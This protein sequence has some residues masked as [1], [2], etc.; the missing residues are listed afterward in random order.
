VGFT[1]SVKLKVISLVILTMFEICTDTMAHTKLGA[2]LSVVV[3]DDNLGNFAHWV[4]ELPNL[5]ESTSKLIITNY[6]S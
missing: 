6:G 4:V 5:Q 3:R 1:R 2:D